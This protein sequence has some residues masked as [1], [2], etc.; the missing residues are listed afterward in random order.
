MSRIEAI[1]EA[2]EFLEVAM[3]PVLQCRSRNSSPASEQG[4]PSTIEAVHAAADSLA[5]EMSKVRPRY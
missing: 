4:G 5:I 2:K 3:N 1:N